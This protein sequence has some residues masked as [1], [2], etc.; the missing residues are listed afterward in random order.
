MSRVR[1]DL[2][3]LYDI[4]EAIDRALAYTSGLSWED[5]LQ[6]HKTQEA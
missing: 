3:F 2:D 1:R 5:Y 4:Q 6:D